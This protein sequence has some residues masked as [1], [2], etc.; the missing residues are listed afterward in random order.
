MLQAFKNL[1]PNAGL[2][3]SV[4][5]HAD[6]MPVPKPFREPPPF[7]PI[8]HNIQNDIEHF[9]VVVSDI[10]S[11]GGETIRHTLVLSLSDLN[12]TIVLT[13]LV[14]FDDKQGISD[15]H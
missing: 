6:S 14:L 1:V 9:K 10:A 4:H 12:H 11:M 15:R 13:Y 3:P 5:A 2:V 8:Y 7:A